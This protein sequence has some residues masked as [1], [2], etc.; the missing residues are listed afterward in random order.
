MPH[1][2]NQTLTLYRKL[3]TTDKDG[4]KKVSWKRETLHYCFV[5][6]TMTQVLSGQ[7]IHYEQAIFRVPVDQCF[8]FAEGDIIMIGDI[9][10]ASPSMDE[11]NTF[12]LDEVRDNS[13]LANAHYYGRSGSE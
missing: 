4:R 2:W 6:K 11:D 10:G 3:Y 9:Q 1:W 13:N 8:M 12:V 7:I 5:K